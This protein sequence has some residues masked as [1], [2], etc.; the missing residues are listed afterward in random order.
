[1]NHSSAE[2]LGK[3]RQ[4]MKNRGLDAWIGRIV[5][6]HLS[7]YVPEHWQSIK[8]LT[9]FTGSAARICITADNAML[10]ADSRYWEQA[11]AELKGSPFEL[12]KL[13]SPNA[14]SQEAWLS[15]HL[16]DG[17]SVGLAPELWSEA[18]VRRSGLKGSTS[19]T[20]RDTA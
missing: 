3:L 16:A 6:P 20:A 14:P 10:L 13:G 19:V 4:V 5:D 12:V 9:G 2:R 17:A 15:A 7:E 8:W 18:D 11:A 1:M